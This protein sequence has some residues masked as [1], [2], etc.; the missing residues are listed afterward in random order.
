MSKRSNSWTVDGS[1]GVVVRFICVLLSR[2]LVCMCCC[3]FQ[4]PF[5]VSYTQYQRYRPRCSN[6][7]HQRILKQLR[8]IENKNR[9]CGVE[10]PNYSFGVNFMREDNNLRVLLWMMTCSC[11]ITCVL[12][13]FHALLASL[14]Y[15]C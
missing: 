6:C 2:F 1:V 15:V 9:R 10:E 14:S 8:T 12:Q 11:P 5:E 13:D 7:F 4:F 3:C